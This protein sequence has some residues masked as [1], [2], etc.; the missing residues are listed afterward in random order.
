M[1]LTVGTLMFSNPTPSPDG[2]KLFVIGQQRRF[3]LIGLNGK[4]QQFSLYLPGVSA[5]EAD[6][7]RSGEWMTYVAHSELTLWRGERG[8]KL[9]THI[10]HG[11]MQARAPR[12]GP[13]RKRLTF[14]ASRS[15]A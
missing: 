11:P 13:Q 12:W 4:S 2:K 8:G 5:G 6:F 1:Q 14:F 9:R 10:A 15:G 7:Q 3:D